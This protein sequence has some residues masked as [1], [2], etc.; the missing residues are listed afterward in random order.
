MKI[1]WDNLLNDEIKKQYKN[2]EDGIDL[3]KKFLA[4]F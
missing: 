1:N 3:I 2:I 4:F